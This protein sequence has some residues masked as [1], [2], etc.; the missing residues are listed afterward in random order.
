MQDVVY[1]DEGM[2]EVTEVYPMNSNGIPRTLSVS[3]SLSSSSSPPSPKASLSLANEIFPVPP[4]NMRKSGAES[5]APLPPRISQ[6][7]DKPAK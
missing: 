1:V 7:E 4:E 2:E 5:D 6:S 3:S